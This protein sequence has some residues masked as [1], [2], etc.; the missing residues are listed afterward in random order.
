MGYLTR[1]NKVSEDDAELDP[2][3]VYL[4][5]LAESRGW[6]D[7]QTKHALLVFTAMD[8]DLG[9]DV[10]VI[11]SDWL[12]DG[13]ERKGVSVIPDYLKILLYDAAA[14]KFC[15]GGGGEWIR[16]TPSYRLVADSID[17]GKVGYQI[18][19]EFGDG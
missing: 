6:T 10:K 15:E 14:R 17:A 2:Q 12:N 4:G 16:G 13:K 3:L 7:L 19:K 8:G 18:D 1:G 5:K 11:V 9:Q